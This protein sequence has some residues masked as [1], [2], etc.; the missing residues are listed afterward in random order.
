MAT[1]NKI[2]F[3]QHTPSGCFWYRIKHVKDALDRAGIETVYLPINE[4]I[5]DEVIDSLMSVQLYG[6]YPFSFEHVLTYLKEKGV[7]IVYD[8]D[9][10][11]ELIPIENPFH[12]SVKKDLGSVAQ[13]LDYADEVTVATP[14]LKEYIEER[15][16]G[17][18]TVIPNC[19]DPLEWTHKRVEHKEIRIG[20]AGASPHVSD[21]IDIIPTI[22][23]LQS[24]Y[25]IKFYLMGFGTTDYETWFKQYRYIAQPEATLELRKLDALLKEI[26]YEWIPFVDYTLYPQVLT[27]MSLDIGLCPLKDTPFNSYRSASKA[28][29]Y[30]LSGALPMSPNSSESYKHDNNSFKVWDWDLQLEALVMRFNKNGSIK[31]LGDYIKWTKE[32]R[33]IDTQIDLLKSVYV[34]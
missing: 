5:D 4:D 15:Y 7:K 30:T 22:K 13:I 21:L 23:T 9:D 14:K 20:F 32:N 6:A 1:R 3:F 10:A 2:G 19:Y 27:E 33:N 16:K 28:M 8:V 25:D 26:K 18:V 34:V 12:A 24:K 17:K 31:E 29:E 11:L